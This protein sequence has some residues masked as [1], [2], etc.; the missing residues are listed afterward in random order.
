M[1]SL[2]PVAEGDYTMTVA[3]TLDGDE[4]HEVDIEVRSERVYRGMTR[5]EVLETYAPLLTFPAEE[6][7]KPTRYEAY[8]ENSV[9]LD[10][11][12]VVYPSAESV[13]ENPT[14]LDLWRYSDDDVAVVPQDFHDE[15]A[16][17]AYQDPTEY[18]RTVYG[19]VHE[20]V[21]FSDHDRIEDGEYTV[22][23]YW[24]MYVHDPKPSDEAGQISKGP[25][26]HT[27]DQEPLF[28]LLDEDGPQWVA[29]Q[30]HFGG[31]LRRWEAV[32]TVGDHPRLFPAEG[33]HSNFFGPYAGG[34][35][36]AVTER[37]ENPEYIY[38]EQFF[39]A[40]DVSDTAGDVQEFITGC[41]TGIHGL[42]RVL[43]FEYTDPIGFNERLAPEQYD[44]AGGPPVDETY[45]IALLTDDEAWS[46]Y[47]G[48]LYAYPRS[49][50][51]LPRKTDGTIPQEQSR[52]P[53]DDL[54]G[55]I[56]EEIYPDH[57]Q[58]DARIL[59]SDSWFGSDTVLVDETDRTVPLEIQNT[60]VQPD[61]FAVTVTVT[62]TD[63]DFE[64]TVEHRAF[65]DT[66]D[67]VTR[68]AGDPR[69]AR[70]LIDDEIIRGSGIVGSTRWL[71]TE[72]IE[73]EV[74]LPE[75]TP[76]G[77][78]EVEIELA[79]YN[80]SIRET[81]D[82]LDTTQ[83]DV[84]VD[85]KPASIEFVDEPSG[86]RTPGEEATYTVEVTNTD[87]ETRTL[88]AGVATVGPQRDDG[89]V[90][91]IDS[92]IYPGSE[93]TVELDPGESETVELSWDVDD[94]TPA[95]VYR[96]VVVVGDRNTDERYGLDISGQA[97]VVR[98]RPQIRD[99]AVERVTEDDIVVNISATNLGAGA[100]SQRM[101][102]SFP[103]VSDPDD[104]RVLDDGT[105][106]DAD[107]VRVREPGER[108]VAEYGRSQTS[109]EAPLLEATAA[110]WGYGETQY[111]TVR[112][113]ADQH[114]ELV[115][116]K[117]T[118]TS[119]G[120]RLQAF[121]PGPEMTAFRDQQSEFAFR[122]R[123]A[124][125]DELFERELSLEEGDRAAYAVPVSI[126]GSNGE[127]F[128]PQRGPLE[129]AAFEGGD[130][131]TATVQVYRPDGGLEDADARTG[132]G[133]ANASSSPSPESGGW[134][135][136]YEAS[137]GGP[138]AFRGATTYPV[139]PL[140]SDLE[141]TD[142]DRQAG[143]SDAPR[144]VRVRVQ[145]GAAGERYAPSTDVNSSMFDVG[146]GD[147]TVPSEDIVVT[148]DRTGRYTLHLTPPPQSEAGEYDLKVAFTDRRLGVERT[149]VAEV[150]EAIAY[151]DEETSRTATAL[152]IDRSGSMGTTPMENARDAARIFTETSTDSDGVAVVSYSSSSRVDQEMVQL[153]E[154][155]Q[156]VL[157]AIDGLSSGGSTN[158]GDGLIDGR[159]ELDSADDGTEKAVILMSD[160]KQNR[161]PSE[162]QML[163]DIIPTYNDR[164]YCLY[165]IAFTGGADEDF[166]RSAAEAADCGFFSEA[167]DSETL[168]EVYGDIRGDVSGES[169]FESELGSVGSGE[170]V[171]GGFFVDE[172][173]SSAVVD[174]RL[175]GATVDPDQSRAPVQ[176]SGAASAVAAPAS[177]D[178]D[179]PEV[180][181]IAPDG[182]VVEPDPETESGT[183]RPDVEYSV[184]GD[185]VVYRIDDPEAGEWEYEI[186]NPT[187][188]PLDYEA[189]AT[190]AAQT[191]L[192]VGTDAD[193]YYTGGD[194]DITGA[195]VGPDGPVQGASVVATVTS[196]SGD[197]REVP[198]EE[199]RAGLY[200]VTVEA[201]EAGTYTVSVRASNDDGLERIETV[202]WT[203][204]AADTSP[205]GLSQADE[206]VNVI[207]GETGT[208][209]VEVVADAAV[210]DAE[211]DLTTLRTADG[212]ALSSGRTDPEVRRL[213]LGTGERQLV[214]VTVSMPDN[215]ATGTYEGRLRVFLA[216]GGVVSTPVSVTAAEADETVLRD[217]IVDNSDTWR[218]VGAAGKRHQES[219]MADHLTRLYERNPA[220]GGLQYAGDRPDDDTVVEAGDIYEHSFA[221]A[222]E[223]DGPIVASVYVEEPGAYD[224]ADHEAVAAGGQELAT[225]ST[226]TTVELDG[227][228]FRRVDVAI[229]D[230]QAAGGDP[231]Q[232]TVAFQTPPS[233]NDRSIVTGGVHGPSASVLPLETTTVTLSTADDD[234]GTDDSA[235]DVQAT[236][237]PTATPTATPAPTATST[238]T[239]TATPTATAA[240][241]A[242]STASAT[243]TAAS[244][245]EEDGPGM[246]VLL[247]A[248][249]VLTA[250]LT[251]LLLAR[252]RGR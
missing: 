243:P 163:N 94:D 203:V 110:P 168:R 227:T 88:S 62:R 244:P 59:E 196:P 41:D 146:I 189:E 252:G 104:V 28:V 22:V 82:V 194:V 53:D 29:A 139:E 144:P 172:S 159:S 1:T 123:L 165:T 48:D 73:A 101:V 11:N 125:N 206:P 68:T 240:P 179:S 153:D 251:A 92:S 180:R 86:I 16:Y 79:L 51:P 107:D 30:Q 83:L 132:N 201:A 157:N 63:G 66:G 185:T 242:T 232:V 84:Q 210:L 135:V 39:C 164:G 111:V 195:L 21:E 198:L 161:G 78:Y 102:V 236:S 223:S 231:I 199:R 229:R 128:Y 239:P 120:G 176:F 42:Y 121:D 25:A 6:R 7:Y 143:G 74:P 222:P 27:G 178:G 64:G 208:V 207:R 150:P 114:G 47:S 49:G 127:E 171:R 142:T 200:G 55:W 37:S 116:L 213:D 10:G 87:D 211:L 77:E 192:E 138:Q 234:G 65:L 99:A 75:N 228:P 129:A 103:T 181:L 31:E 81:P 13:V 113:P 183:T 122:L 115:H 233:T 182:T 46:D 5:N 40:D 91:G 156:D 246:G 169:V 245:T 205:I 2:Q 19:G 248:L 97:V 235:P 98:P 35:E 187:E 204:D 124:E 56:D 190:G 90:P 43:G 76:A 158:I 89:G 4:T 177:A 149:V 193:Q 133:T 3:V 96:G 85:R 67:I 188:E 238:P 38:Q 20:D 36:T 249:A 52:W 119:D 100:E 216:D 145:V 209:P 69:R 191:T 225:E 170:T 237:T 218:T 117:T 217:R 32:N 160:G 70:G 173:A 184:T 45:E 17:E 15:A 108:T 162:S 61:D 57:E 250:A 155:R 106:F 151:T 215:A 23:S 241:T 58:T 137:E 202:E 72:I 33:A 226:T 134:T 174:V 50:V 247:A 147:N 166:L 167:S 93:A 221:V 71:E 18:P 131:R 24:M 112:L 12:A 219:R 175:F 95:G 44:E 148:T 220:T 186:I 230:P 152:V 197:T 54:P 214:N 130:G 118:A 212:D 154:K 109:L 60:G 105:S 224:V 9:L 141:V 140:P 8:V 136:A 34:T 80:E 26:V 14:L 126:P